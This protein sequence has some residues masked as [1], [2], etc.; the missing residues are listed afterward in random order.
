MTEL[1]WPLERNTIRRNI[2]NNA[3]GAGVRN[4]GTRDHQGWDLVAAPM[5]SCYAIADGTIVLR[6]PMHLDYGNMLVLEFS[7]R[8]RTLY[9][10]YC[11]LI[12]MPVR[13]D[14]PVSRGDII[15]YTGN[16]GN[17]FTMRG[18]DQHLHFEIR[19]ALNPGG[20]LAN[21]LDPAT[22]YGRAPIGWTFFDGH[23]GKLA[24]FGGLP[25]LKV[26]GINVR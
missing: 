12:L 5:T 23:G 25:G 1:A 17:A 8:G 3:F 4:G 18:E 24:S 15:G 16:T 22:L 21:R 6:R 14:M 26:Y 7:Y 9:A 11:H 19:T 2:R 10:A 13:Q 20:G